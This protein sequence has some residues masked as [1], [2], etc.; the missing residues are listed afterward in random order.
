ME[1]ARESI[2]SLMNIAPGTAVIKTTSGTK[3]VPV[4]E[5]EI[6]DMM[7][8][9]HGDK[10]SMDG[11]IRYGSSDINQAAI[12]GESLPVTKFTR[13]ETCAC[14]LNS[15]DYMEVEVTKQNE[16]I[17]LT[18]IIRIFVEAKRKR[19]HAQHFMD[20]FAKY[21]SPAIIAAALL[22]AV[23]PPLF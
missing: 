22:V 9:K 10:L 6:G 13:D 16:D 4:E 1:K 21:Y 8:I 12:T 5:A 23:I 19:A 7:V 2:Q 17:T 11:I 14:K 3:T 18:K 20:Q 15:S